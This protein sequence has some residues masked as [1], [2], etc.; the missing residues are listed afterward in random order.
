M[1]TIFLLFHLILV[2]FGNLTQQTIWDLIML[3][4]YCRSWTRFILFIF[5]TS[6]SLADVNDKIEGIAKQYAKNLIRNDEIVTSNGLKLSLQD[7]EKGIWSDDATYLP[8]GAI[9]VSL[10]DYNKDGHLDISLSSS[11]NPYVSDLWLGGEKVIRNLLA[12]LP[13]EKL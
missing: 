7:P 5:L 12:G 13:W 2:V 10:Y 3:I 8:G 6:A 4:E 9:F 1:L 11:M